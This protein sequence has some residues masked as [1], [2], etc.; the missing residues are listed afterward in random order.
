[1]PPASPQLWIEG[2]SH[3]AIRELD[4]KSLESENHV[5]RKS[6]ETAAVGVP[7]GQQVWEIKS[8]DGILK[9]TRTDLLVASE[10]PFSLLSG[11][12]ESGFS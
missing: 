2:E 8:K 11:T 7:V 5:G 12:I 1:M 6:F 4:V 9:G 3:Q 10:Y